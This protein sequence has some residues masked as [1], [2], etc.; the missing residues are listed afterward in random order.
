MIRNLFCTVNGDL[1]GGHLVIEKFIQGLRSN[2]QV[3]ELATWR[4][5]EHSSFTPVLVPKK[6]DEAFLEPYDIIW[7]ASAMLIPQIATKVSQAR[8]VL[9][10][11]GFETFLYGNTYALAMENI[12]PL[13]DAMR[14]A[15]A[16]VATSRSIVE[17]VRSRLQRDAFYV[18]LN[19]NERNFFH[20]KRLE[21]GSPVRIMMVGSYV[22]PFK[23]MSDAFAAL[24]RLSETHAIE[25]V[26]VSSEQR[27]KAK[28]E[29]WRFAIER[30][31]GLSEDQ[32]A[33]IYRSCDLFLCPSWYE[34]LG[35]PVLE[36][37]ACGLPVV[38]T[39]NYGVS[40]YGVDRFNLLIAEPA[41][42]TDLEA[43]LRE[44]L[45]D[46][47]LRGFLAENAKIT[48]E[49]FAAQPTMQVL[50]ECQQKILRLKENNVEL[51]EAL[52][53]ERRLEAAGVFTPL[54][55]HTQIE[56]IHLPLRR[57]CHQ[58]ISGELSAGQAA[59][60]LKKIADQIRP[61]LKNPKAE[62][63]DELKRRMD[64][65]QLLIALSDQPSLFAE[66]VTTIVS[67]AGR[68][69]MAQQ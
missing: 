18:P 46:A 29:N 57:T 6:F 30:H 23:G 7:I 39:S 65:C 17:L 55:V 3:A 47:Q 20:A 2:G 50:M 1:N 24:D 27:Q 52:S 56:S 69:E 25:L 10:C 35:L 66:R 61:L 48:A 44:L 34:G 60:E 14:C 38:C 43:K 8:T 28:L 45:N 37:F 40:D 26:L 13:C 53:L 64:F 4:M 58:I 32:M 15:T 21:L 62:Y 68:S 41:N 22:A 51:S 11:Q 5:T 33:D 31:D 36:A 67:G 59:V 63:F 49:K 19:L 12:E 54:A 42:P 9:L 16:I